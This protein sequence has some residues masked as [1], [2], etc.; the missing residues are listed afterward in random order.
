MDDSL[1]C[2][3]RSRRDAGYITSRGNRPK[4]QRRPCGGTYAGS[5]VRRGAGRRLSPP[6]A[7]S[8]HLPDHEPRALPDRDLGQGAADGV[9]GWRVTRCPSVAGAAR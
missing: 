6:G 4:V 5:G 2:G 9:P 1:A 8:T 7:E 3:M